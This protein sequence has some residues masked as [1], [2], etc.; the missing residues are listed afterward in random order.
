MVRAQLPHSQQVSA[1]F[2]AD[3]KLRRRIDIREPKI[4]AARAEIDR[5]G[6]EIELEV[7]CGVTATAVGAPAR[8]GATVFC[9]GSALFNGPI[10]MTDRVR[11]L[12]QVAAAALQYK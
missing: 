3:C 2:T 8:A 12:R 4:A 11:A 10:T 7:D 9:A 1:A 6:G 5:L